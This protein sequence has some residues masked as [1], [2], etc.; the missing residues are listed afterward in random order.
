MYHAIKRRLKRLKQWEHYE[1]LQ[2]VME[3]AGLLLLIGFVGFMGIMLSAI[4]YGG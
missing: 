1:L 4:V 2:A 3:G